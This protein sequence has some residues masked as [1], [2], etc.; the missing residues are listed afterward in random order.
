MRWLWVLGIGSVILT[1]LIGGWGVA[2]PDEPPVIPV[3]RPGSLARPG[4]YRLDRN[5]KVKKHG[6]VIR[7]SDVILDLNGK[8]IMHRFHPGCRHNLLVIEARGNVEI[9]NGRIIGGRCGICLHAPHG[10]IRIHHLKFERQRLSAI[11]AREGEDGGKLLIEDNIISHAGFY[12]IILRRV[13]HATIRNNTIDS[14]GDYGIYVVYSHGG[15]IE[16]NHIQVTNI[17]ILVDNSKENHV[18]GNR[19]HYSYYSIYLF[20]SFR[21][22]IRKNIMAF[23]NFGIFHYKS[24]HN[25]VK[26]NKRM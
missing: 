1:G 13:D 24:D 7:S 26:D 23:S 15:H 18:E 19:I 4:F 8:S 5:L 21:N 9:R 12:G 2:Q 22:V 16:N 14:A 25:T 3:T 17:G 10:V 11:F 6:L 20:K